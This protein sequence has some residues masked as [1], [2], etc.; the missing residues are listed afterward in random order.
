MYNKTIK[1]FSTF[2]DDGHESDVESDE[3]LNQIDDGPKYLK[4]F[5]DE[6]NVYVIQPR[7]KWGHQK[8]E[9]MSR[10]NSKM[11]LEEAVSLVKTLK[12][13]NVI[14]QKII[15]TTNINQPYFFGAGKIEEIARNIAENP[16]I[17][18]IFLSINQMHGWQQHALEQAFGVEVFDRFSVV[19]QIF[20]DHATTK[21][22]KLQVALA[23][24]PY[25]RSR[26][27]QITDAKRDRATGTMGQCGS[28]ET[29]YQL[30]QR[31]LEEREL[32]LKRALEKLDRNREKLRSK[33]RIMKFPTVSVVGYTNSG[34]TS[35]IKSLTDDSSLEPKDELFAT[36][37]VT[38]HGGRLGSIKKV[39][40]VDTV[41]FICDI[42]SSLIQAFNATL[43]EV[44]LSDLVIHV[45]DVSNPD[46]KNQRLT[47]D[48]T[49]NK[50]LKIGSKL[51]TTMIHVGNKMD[52]LQPDSPSP[53]GCDVLTSAMKGTNIALLKEEIEKRLFMNMAY[54][55]CE[56]R[57]EMGSNPY[58]WLQQNCNIISQHVDEMDHNFIFLVVG[59]NE[60]TF[61]RFKKIF[62][63]NFFV[64]NEKTSSLAQR[65]TV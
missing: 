4:N 45:H 38:V 42:P 51:D 6:R 36:L 39:L 46:L 59:F 19:L 47:V 58:S 2:D 63:C 11:Q 12:N 3:I 48:H 21:E 60:I 7:S 18:T 33:R 29:Y 16:K 35:L 43:R 54:F 14:D 22:A 10:T 5:S 13:W 15:N 64:G 52:K 26:L 50:E 40:Y 9:T 57:V 24:I 31:L 49:L 53:T 37:D 20:N 28:G 27:R 32:K 25:I 61:G 41:G 8:T 34:K 65:Y 62:G 30:R 55:Q 56:A 44:T 17:N 1:H 23:E